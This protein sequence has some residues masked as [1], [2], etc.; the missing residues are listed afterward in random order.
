MSAHSNYE[1]LIARLDAFIRK[2]YLNRLIRGLLF[3]AAGVVS[4]YL[5]FSFLEYRFYFPSGVRIVLFWGFLAGTLYA[6]GRYIALP[7]AKYYRLGKTISHM[8]AARI[9]GDHFGDIQDKLLNILELRE[10]ALT[11][12][13]AALIEAGISQ[14][15]EKIRPIPFTMAI[16]LGRNRKYL[17]YALPPLAVLVFVVF[18]APNVLKDSNIRLI[19]N[20]MHF[21]R[22]APFQFRVLHNELE[23]VQYED[24]TLKM[25]VSGQVLPE[26]VAVVTPTGTYTMQKDGADSYSYVFNKVAGDTKFHFLANGFTSKEFTLRVVPKP[27]LLNFDIR[28]NY[29]DYTGITDITLE[30]TGDLLV[31][32]GTNLEWVFNTEN[33]D[34]IELFFAEQKIQASKDGGDRYTAERRAM[35]NE[36]YKIG[37]ANE[38][39]YAKD[40]IAYTIT[41]IPD[42]HPQIT[43]EQFVDSTDDKFLYFLGQTSDD[44]GCRALNFQYTIEGRDADE[45]FYTREQ[46]TQAIAMPLSKENKFT[47]AFDLRA[48]NLQPGDRVTYYFEVWDNDGV[49]G[50]KSTRTPA[51][52]YVV[53]TLDELQ[54]IKDDNN[55]NIKDKLDDILDDLQDVQKQT[56]KLEEKFLD[57]KELNWEDKKQLENLLQKNQNIQ[58]QVKELQQDFQKNL[59]MQKDYL[60]PDPQI[61]EKQEMLQQMLEEVLPEEMQKLMDEIQK[62]MEELNREKGVEEMQEMQMNNEQLE[63]ELDRMLE[64]FKQLELEQKMN[65]TIEKLNEL[66]QEQEQLSEQTDQKN[67]DNQKNIEKQNELNEK[68]DEIQKDMQEMREMNEQLEEQKDLGDTQEQ[69]QQIDQQMQQAGQQMQKN[70]KKQASQNQKSAAQKMQ[71]MA[72][73][74]E[75][76]MQ[77]SSMEQQMEDMNA[78]RRLIDNLVMLSVEQEALMKEVKQIKS[79]NPK[80]IDLMAQQQKIKEDTRMVEDS[81]NALAKRVFQISSFITRE[82]SAVNENLDKSVEQMG[83]RQVKE[84]NL[85]QQQVMTGY[86]NL[87]L[88]LDEVMQQMQEQMAKSMPGSQMC[89]KPGGSSDSQMPSMS[90]MQK[91]LNEQLQKMKGQME[92]G[93]KAGGQQGTS[94]ELAEMAQKQAAIRQA[95]QEMAK[96]LGGG[97]TEDGKLA[98]ELQ[99]LADQMDQTEEDIVNKRITQETIMRQEEILTRLLEAEE[100]ERKRK[101]DNERQSN[102]AQEINRPVPPAIE[103]YLRKRAAELDLYKTVSPELKPFYKNLVEE[104]LR[105]ITY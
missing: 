101:Q 20:T 43:A 79:T 73:Q 44:Y 55:E 102:T 48:K 2:Y 28:V 38:Q 52:Q 35:Q 75:Q 97:N 26:L 32:E 85:Y 34:R 69:E 78:L 93:Q 60:E 45:N 53:P 49:H 30:N 88:M 27:T 103:E 104:Y 4:A 89:Q 46:N 41:V 19:K 14:K 66:S 90:E 70:N 67:A 98:K 61:L 96:Q 51:M 92:K 18:A 80:F 99:K 91:Q 86:N 9:I 62:L 10:Q 5:L 24:F 54:D 42:A 29:P 21:E 84:S 50:S 25:Q 16:D 22:E 8:E 72:Q 40:T 11:E 1:M 95:L 68:F 74:M 7:L 37:I 77:Q 57:K 71:E 3:T 94:K 83:E 65:E 39:V 23:V 82:V 13:D 12:R 105:S 33:T 76:S 6:V 100:S 59:E 56:D 31:P 63:Q 36:P 64:L 15:I 81:L 87:A 17:K 58:Q 47:H